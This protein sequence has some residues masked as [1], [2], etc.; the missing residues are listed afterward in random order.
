MTFGI[1]VLE[2][3]F[4]ATVSIGMGD[5]IRR[6]GLGLRGIAV[7]ALLDSMADIIFGDSISV[8]FG[9]RV[10]RL[11][12]G[13]GESA[14]DP[15][16]PLLR[17]LADSPTVTSGAGSSIRRLTL[18]AWEADGRFRVIVGMVASAGTTGAGVAGDRIAQ[19]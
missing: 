16:I 7:A 4:W 8:D 19:G 5:S 13:P 18:R 11:G 10:G 15:G 3:S 6:F 12:A 1:T 9:R 14:G 2:L 17:C